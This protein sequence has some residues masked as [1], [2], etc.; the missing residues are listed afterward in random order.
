[1]THRAIPNTIDSG[2]NSSPLPVVGRFPL[3]QYFV[4]H[5]K[6]KSKSRANAL[7]M[8]FLSRVFANDGASRFFKTFLLRF[9]FDGGSK[10]SDD[11]SG[12]MRALAPAL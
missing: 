9:L 2:V 4:P 7:V 8:E 6:S 3:H 5:F 1:M 12:T 11:C 10:S